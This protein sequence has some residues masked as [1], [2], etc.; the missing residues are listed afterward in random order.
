MSKAWGWKSE[1]QMLS[2]L[3]GSTFGPEP[4]KRKDEI[5]ADRQR[6][7]ETVIAKKLDLKPT[8][9]VLDLGS[10]C[11]FMAEPIA[12]K[13]AHLYCADISPDFA[14]YCSQET[15]SLANVSVLVIPFAN[16]DQLV[17]LGV[18]KAFAHAVFI[19]FSL[20]DSVLYFRELRKVLP[21]GGLL[22]IDINDL[23]RIDTASNEPFNKHLGYYRS[24]RERLFGLMQWHSVPAYVRVAATEGFEI[25]EATPS[26]SGAFTQLLFRRSA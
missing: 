11:G 18:T 9:V 24:D 13:A 15:R 7:A 25:V 2:L 20:F 22:L 5:R 26:K 16:L 4:E 21:A 1:R 10:G 6:Y 8:D 17:G 3:A 14:D 12:R 19:H 23:D